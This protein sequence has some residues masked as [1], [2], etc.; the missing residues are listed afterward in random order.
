MNS[1]SFLTK[2]VKFRYG[3][4]P[5]LTIRICFLT[6]N[7]NFTGTTAYWKTFWRHWQSTTQQLCPRG[8]CPWTTEGTPH[9]GSTPGPTSET[10]QSWGVPSDSN[11]P[12]SWFSLQY[13][14]HYLV[15]DTFHK[16][17]YHVPNNI[18]LRGYYESVAPL[19][20]WIMS[21]DN[22]IWVYI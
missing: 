4:P 15:F 2:T 1:C 21:N 9:S 5:Y 10:I 18:Y 3:A 17:Q 19:Y 11:Q 7:N 14:F 12:I 16:P 20:I 22:S 6:F 8:T 13:Y